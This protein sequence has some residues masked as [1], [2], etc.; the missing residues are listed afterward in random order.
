MSEGSGEEESVLARAQRERTAQ[1]RLGIAC[2][3]IAVLF[4]SGM[5]AAVKEASL[6]GVPIL[7]IIFFRSAFALVPLMGLGIWRSGFRL[8]TTRYPGAHV[9]RAVVGIASMFCTFAALSML[10]F[11]TA[12]AIGFTTPL[13]LTLLSGPLLGEPVSRAR[14]A[15]TAVGFAGVAIVLNPS[16]EGGGLGY[17]LALAGALLTAGVIISVRQL[18]HEPALV[19]TSYFTAAT[20]IASLLTLPFGWIMPS[21]WLL[22]LMALA[23]VLGGLAQLLM[24]Q[25]LRYA[26]PSALV[27]LDYTQLIWASLLGF[28]LWG[29]A[30]SARTLL[31]GAVIIGCGCF[32]AFAELRQRKDVA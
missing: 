19:T 30:P 18:A 12:V 23:G 6:A 5:G 31:G 4:F 25:S 22:G 8:P 7:E 29:E 20:T 10:P 21:P 1:M 26:P 16:L 15:A 32:I 2:R 17:G 3:L 14:W 11:S 24:T 13:F 27:S 9:K 28:M